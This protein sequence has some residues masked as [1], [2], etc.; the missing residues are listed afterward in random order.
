MKVVKIGFVSDAYGQDGASVTVI[1]TLNKKELEDFA[2]KFF[3][4]YEASK[5]KN[6]DKIA[7]NIKKKLS[8]TD[9]QLLVVKPERI[10]R[11][12]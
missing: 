9:E 2:N 4:A 10:D 12:Y 11:F 5:S 6:A 8:L 3:D 1:T 7:K